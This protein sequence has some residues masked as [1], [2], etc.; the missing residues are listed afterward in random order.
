MRRAQPANASNE[1]MYLQPASFQLYVDIGL[2][3]DP[4]SAR[5]Y[6]PA[7]SCNVPC[8]VHVLGLVFV[9]PAGARHFA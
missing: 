2:K 9:L 7:G 1:K 6:L 5:C 3:L 4:S 8:T